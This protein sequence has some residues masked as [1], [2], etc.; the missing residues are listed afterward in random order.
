MRFLCTG[1]QRT[2]DEAG[3]CPFDR[4]QLV[5]L[6]EGR[7]GDTGPL[8]ALALDGRHDTAVERHGTFPLT[9]TPRPRPR[10]APAPA[11]AP[12]D[13]G[14]ER[15]EPEPW[16]GL[17]EP[18]ADAP[19]PEQPTD[20]EPAA[21]EPGRELD[22][23]KLVGQT[24]DG[25]Y[26]V[27]K[28][29]GEGGMGVVFAARHAV[30]ERPLAIKVLKREAMRDAATARRFVQ[31][32]KAAS[33]IGHPNII[34][35]T[36]FGTTPDGMTYSVMEY[37]GGQ[38]LGAAI[39]EGAPL[40]MGRAAR[41]AVQ[42]ARALGAAH[43]KG[44]VHRDLK[45]ENVFLVDR[46]GRPDFVKIVDF[47]IAKVTRVGQSLDEPRLTRVGSVFGTPEYMA[48]EQ[49]AGK[50]DTDG[51][52][53][54]YALGVILYQMVTGRLP[55]KGESMV[56]TLAMQM[57]DP[58]EPPSKVR[59]DLGILPELE[60]LIMKAL[61]KKRE[62]RF[63]TMGELV[64]ELERLQASA[65]LS[66]TGPVYALAPLPPGAD[67]A[68]ATAPA[69]TTPYPAAATAAATPYPAA[70]AS[71][72]YPA[73]AASEPATPWPP[74]A[75]V[76][77][78]PAPTPVTPLP[79]PVTPLPAPTPTTPL[80]A[81]VTRLPAPTPTTPLPHV[82]S[83]TPVPGA[84]AAARLHAPQPVTDLSGGG[85]V[86]GERAPP[87][88]GPAGPPVRRLKDEP[89]F[90]TS[91]KRLALDHAF[92]D[93]PP[94][95]ARRSWP[96]LL[97]LGVT[98]VGAAAAIALVVKSR[99]RTGADG[100]QAPAPPHTGS[101]AVALA[102]EPDADTSPAAAPPAG[103]AGTSLDDDA[104]TEAPAAVALAPPSAGA[105]RL[106]RPPEAGSA[107]ATTIN[108]QRRVDIQVRTKPEGASLFVGKQYRGPSGT[109]LAEPFGTKLDV[110]CKQAGYK[111]GTVKL[112]F[113]G[114][115]QAALCVL[116][117]TVVCIPGVKNP[118]DNCPD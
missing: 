17:E 83:A 47:G 20:P 84:S 28:K 70:A 80:P 111:N 100:S 58:A 52:V 22:Y 98:V 12:T 88:A 89:E 27:E 7:T 45:P 23:D 50:S 38:T 42:L 14:A 113:D 10:P 11:P 105:P 114:K 13:A 82:M 115:R 118:F 24:L 49:A 57:L 37:V 5:A 39:R 26:Y 40:T 1:C 117:R 48:P 109:R 21:A 87:L 112:V 69:P 85:G 108:P 6:S 64:A 62:Q 25:R 92:A 19:V 68:L 90:V 53:D 102:P 106:P 104:P 99:G 65:G 3:F 78:L 107:A 32:A 79:A 116:Q 44:I 43:D 77:Q 95:P 75:P 55:H 72:P 59:P 103:S 96:I 51:R 9:P 56:R 35:V 29:I 41:I 101:S 30:I 4:T 110:T 33:R 94:P 74:P 2:F 91:P 66:S 34:D 60:A 8:Q 81:P 67:P 46:D 16:A 86:S 54:I 18:P 15:T 76:T 93:D 71:T 31:E 63:Q 36:D 73:A 61:A 97:L